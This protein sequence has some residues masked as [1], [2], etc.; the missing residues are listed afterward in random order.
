MSLLLTCWAGG[1]L[2]ALL[3][4]MTY[5]FAPIAV[6]LVTV[7]LDMFSRMATITLLLA[8]FGFVTSLLA[9]IAKRYLFQ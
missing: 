8:F 9:F 1:L 4:V 5:F 6:G 7:F 2:R 3:S